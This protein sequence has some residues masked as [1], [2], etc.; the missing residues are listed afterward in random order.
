M[1][2]ALTDWTRSRKDITA[3]PCPGQI[4]TKVFEFVIGIISSL[5]PGPIFAAFAS[6]SKQVLKP[7]WPIPI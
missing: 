5:E 4:P 7:F 2:A 1:I 3:N 6:T